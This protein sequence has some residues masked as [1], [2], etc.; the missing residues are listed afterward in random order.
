MRNKYIHLIRLFLL[1]M[2]ASTKL[3]ATSNP[4]D[5][6]RNE[7]RNAHSDD[8]LLDLN[9]KMVNYYW[10]I[11]PIDSHRLYILNVYEIAKRK[12]NDTLI[13]LSH[14]EL[15]TNLS[16][17]HE[18]TS[19][20]EEFFTALDYFKK[21]NLDYKIIQT[22]KDIGAGYKGL[23]NYRLALDYLKLS[24]PSQDLGVRQR[25]YSHMAECYLGMGILD[26]A[27]LCAKLANVNNLNQDDRYANARNLFLFGKCYAKLNDTLL[28]NSYFRSCQAII[29][30]NNISVSYLN[31]EVEFAKSLMEQGKIQD[32]LHYARL[33]F[34]NATKRHDLDYQEETSN[35]L[36]EIFRK[37][38]LQDS[39]FQYAKLSLLLT[40]SLQLLKATS[41]EKSLSLRSYMKEQEKDKQLAIEKAEKSHS[42][43]FVLIY[44]FIIT[45]ILFFGI[46][47]YSALVNEKFINYVGTFLLLM[48]FESLNLVLHPLLGSISHS[49]L[50]IVSFMTGVAAIMIPLHH[51]FEHWFIDFL[52]KTNLRKHRERAQQTNEELK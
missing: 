12:K 32:A 21:L 42:G 49:P 17:S 37:S 36:S 30:D 2:I 4:L 41:N 44:I 39:A 50:I 23:K 47:A 43:Q 8:Q 13:A 19:A 15:G 26:S 11:G 16:I 27:L 18:Y 3:A 52:R 5:S 22:Y 20:I 28:S 48:L 38:N 14:S 33:G 1:A 7:I 25:A 31:Y 29:E 51:K 10:Q 35:L 34:S 45:L 6:L 24:I 9:Q 46:L 40:D